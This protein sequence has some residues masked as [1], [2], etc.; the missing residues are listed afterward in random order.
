MRQLS[1][2]AAMTI[3]VLAPAARAQTQVSA[4][5]AGSSFRDCQDVCPEMVVIPPGQF[6][7]GSP[8]SEPGRYDHE[9]PQHQVTL[10]YALA[11]GKFDV[12]RDQY[13]VFVAETQRPDPPSCDTFNASGQLAAAA[14]LN[15]HNPGFPQTGR[16]PVVCVSWDDAKAYTAWLSA[17]TGR[18]Y[19][20]L[21]EAEYEY[22]ARAG[23][24]GPRYGS[25]DEDKLCSYMN[26]GDLS[27][28][29]TH[30]GDTD[31]TK[32]CND[33]YAYTSPANAFPPNGFGLYDMLGNVLQW[34][35]DCWSESYV[36]APTDGSP[37]RTG[38]CTKH[39]WRGGNW[40]DSARYVRAAYRNGSD[41]G[42]RG[43]HRGFRV[44]RT[45]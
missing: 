2:L 27:Y 39:A 37:S 20:L 12:T 10:S 23:T 43:T 5:S 13:A 8:D 41:A 33:G 16:D 19:R 44:A 4:A 22:A 25:N 17:K 29:Q 35:E 1:I 6:T 36:G 18:S 32:A 40:A 3:L 45:D 21:S 42:D 30:P 34:T 14:G 24:T 9:G 31:V 28:S 15:W 26:L 7:M 38:D 11:V